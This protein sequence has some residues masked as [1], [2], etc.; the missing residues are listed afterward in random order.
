MTII[1]VLLLLR[2]ALFICVDILGQ[3]A[4]PGLD[5]PLPTT[6][7]LHQLRVLPISFVVV[8]LRVLALLGLRLD[9]LFETLIHIIVLHQ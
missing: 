8:T 1:I 3:Q 9:V 4:Q 5:E 7:S 2:V 6:L